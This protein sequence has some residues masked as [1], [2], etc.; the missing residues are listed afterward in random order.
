M[1]A[2]VLD[3]LA[4]KDCGC[5]VRSRS[6][7]ACPRLWCTGNVLY[8]QCKLRSIHACV[9]T[10]SNQAQELLIP[11]VSRP[12]LLVRN[13]HQTTPYSS[14]PMP[15]TNPSQWSGA[16]AVWNW[17][18]GYRDD[19]SAIR[20]EALAW[21]GSG[22]GFRCGRPHWGRGRE[23]DGDSNKSEATC[24]Q[25]VRN[26]SAAAQI[27][28][29]PSRP[30]TVTHHGPCRSVPSPH[31]RARLPHRRQPRG[32]SKPMH[33]LARGEGVPPRNGDPASPSVG[34]WPALA[35][36]SII[37]AVWRGTRSAGFPSPTSRRRSA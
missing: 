32:A 9:P 19:G 10:S 6:T 25:A 34:S 13:M 2:E 22:L 18:G 1:H 17:R 15:Q 23:R 26:P 14:Q 21:F 33:D 12:N 37:A 24:S 28:A 3:W 16:V 30:L 29:S 4:N 20:Q 27:P 8:K 35:A 5:L 7:S 36:P 11:S 31:S